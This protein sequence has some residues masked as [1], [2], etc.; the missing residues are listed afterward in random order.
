MS[1]PARWPGLR[2][3][4][5]WGLLPVCSSPQGLPAHIHCHVITSGYDPQISIDR[6]LQMVHQRMS[7][8]VHGWR[9]GGPV[10]HAGK[11][12]PMSCP[13]RADGTV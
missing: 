10:C 7:E 2:A 1:T 8:D 5:L 9:E 6:D 13:L 3:A 11:L 12:E 4:C